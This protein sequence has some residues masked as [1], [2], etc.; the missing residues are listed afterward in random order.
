MRIKAR[1]GNAT[2]N[3]GRGQLTAAVEPVGADRQAAVA[4][5]A[6]GGSLVRSRRD[7]RVRSRLGGDA[8]L[9]DEFSPNLHRLTLSLNGKG[10]QDEKQLDFGMRRF[11]AAGHAIHHQRTPALS[12]RHARMPCVPQDRLSALRRESWRRICRIMKSYGLNHLRFHSWCPPEAAFAAADVEGIIIQA[13]GPQANVESGQD[14]VRDAFTE[15]ELLRIIRD[16][17]QPPVV[18]PDDPGQRIRR[19]RRGAGAM[20]RDAHRAKTRGTVFLGLLPAA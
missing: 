7:G 12:A 10:T 3:A 15:A 18:L 6:A 20:G 2:G 16:L 13:E 14:A 1:I 19:K 5:E 4:G 9:W 17:R 11:A 8:K